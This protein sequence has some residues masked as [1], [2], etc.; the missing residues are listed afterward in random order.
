MMERGVIKQAT[1][2]TLDIPDIV[3]RE[4]KDEITDGLRDKEVRK[5]FW[6][7]KKKAPGI[8]DELARRLTQISIDSFQDMLDRGSRRIVNA[9]K[10]IKRMDDAGKP[11]WKT[12]DDNMKTRAANMIAAQEDDIL[13]VLSLMWS[14]LIRKNAKGSRGERL[15]PDTDAGRKAFEQWYN[16]T[17][18][19]L[20]RART[21]VWLKSRGLYDDTMKILGKGASK[22]LKRTKE[23]YK[24]AKEL[25]NSNLKSFAPGIFK[26]ARNTEA[27][28]LAWAQYLKAQSEAGGVD[29]FALAMNKG[30]RRDVVR[31]MIEHFEAKGGRYTELAPELA[32]VYVQHFHKFSKQF[33]RWCRWRGRFRG[34]KFGIHDID[35]NPI[36]WVKTTG[37]ALPMLCSAAAVGA[38]WL[39]PKSVEDIGKLSRGESLEDSPEAAC[40]KQLAEIPKEEV[41]LARILMP[42]DSCREA[43]Y[44]E[45]MTRFKNRN[46]WTKAEALKQCYEN[47]DKEPNEDECA[48][49]NNFYDGKLFDF[50]PIPDDPY[51]QPVDVEGR[52]VPKPSYDL[53]Q[54]LPS[55]CTKNRD[56]YTGM[57]CKNGK[58]VDEPD[59]DFD[60]IFEVNKSLFDDI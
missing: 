11:A 39:L 57:I 10:W 2:G 30:R 14:E 5:A 40:D 13:D 37:Y 48:A 42:N 16:E 34:K 45:L 6:A 3:L 36:T 33:L 15:Y 59:P 20:T 8:V 12:F 52:P 43:M 7:G 28:W 26:K 18:K 49:L 21:E 31:E 54:Q 24:E 58:C 25:F 35:F 1:D 32:E 60:D 56:C 46:E 17:G 23:R 9:E 51:T 41:M 55:G 44:K 19:H 47:S 4:I 38:A 50:A 53:E 22:A 27:A 29:M